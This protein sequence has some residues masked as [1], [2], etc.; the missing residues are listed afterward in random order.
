MNYIY[1]QKKILLKRISFCSGIFV[2]TIIRK[3]IK[4][5]K[6]N[7]SED[8]KYAHRSG[9]TCFKGLVN[10]TCIYNNTRIKQTISKISQNENAISRW[11]IREGVSRV[12]WKC[13]GRHR[14]RHSARA[15]REAMSVIVIDRERAQQC[16][17][18]IKRGKASSGFSWSRF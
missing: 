8:P 3:K 1:I 10:T 14:N 18:K 17:S 11:T 15:C 5:G 16:F 7:F 4:L 13:T 6:V 9:E 2:S 12:A